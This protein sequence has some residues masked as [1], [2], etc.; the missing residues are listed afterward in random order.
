MAR[1]LFSS[2][3]IGMQ[4]GVQYKRL[5]LALGQPPVP[6]SSVW[7]LDGMS[8]IHWLVKIPPVLQYLKI[9]NT[10]RGDMLYTGQVCVH[11]SFA[12]DPVPN[13]SQ[14]E[15]LPNRLSLPKYSASMWC[16]LAHHNTA[17]KCSLERDT[18]TLESCVHL[19]AVGMG[20]EVS[21]FVRALLY[22]KWILLHLHHTWHLLVFPFCKQSRSI[23]RNI[24]PP[25]NDM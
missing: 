25:I 6:A 22:P 12:P 13:W 4:C 23:R 3:S 17:V 7:G 1:Q 19:N 14:W 24:P 11:Q 2:T 15:L 16:Y 18:G 5:Q 21:K 10:L 8:S 20:T 9:T